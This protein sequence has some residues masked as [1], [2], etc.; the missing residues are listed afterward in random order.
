MAERFGSRKSIVYY[1]DIPVQRR[2]EIS[3]FLVKSNFKSHKQFS[4]I[5]YNDENIIYLKYLHGFKDESYDFSI[6]KIENDLVKETHE[7]RGYDSLEKFIKNLAKNKDFRQT[8]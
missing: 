6:H 2:H 5:F 3:W 7:I 8:E 1:L 4:K